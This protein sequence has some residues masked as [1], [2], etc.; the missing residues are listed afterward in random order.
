[1]MLPIGKALKD[2]NT[3]GGQLPYDEV[4]HIDGF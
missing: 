3:R 2:A 4:V 1:M